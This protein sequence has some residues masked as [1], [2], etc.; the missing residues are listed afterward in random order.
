MD[1]LRIDAYTKYH[2]QHTPLITSISSL[3]KLDGQEQVIEDGKPIFSTTSPN[4]PYGLLFVEHLD[5]FV[6]LINLNITEINRYVLRD[7]KIYINLYYED[8]RLYQPTKRIVSGLK[9][10][11]KFNGDV[12]QIKQA[13]H[14]TNGKYA[15]QWY[16]IATKLYEIKKQVKFLQ[17]NVE[18]LRKKSIM[19]YV[20][21]HCKQQIQQYTEQHDE[22]QQL[23]K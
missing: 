12:E 5:L 1:I 11:V 19:G 21:N 15:D 17:V 10:A 20:V 3:I 8:K 23:R 4:K 22:L 9:T 6:Q 7:L 2:I 13:T 18:F 14:K 16:D